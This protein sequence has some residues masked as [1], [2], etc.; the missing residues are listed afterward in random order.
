VLARYDY[1]Q[2]GRRARLTRG[3]GTKTEI[4]YDWGLNLWKLTHDLAWTDK[5]QNAE[6]R[7]NAANQIVGRVTSNPQYDW[8]INAHA[9]RRYRHDAQNKVVGNTPTGGIEQAITYHSSGTLASDGTSSFGYDADNRLTSVARPEKPSVALAYDA[10]GRLAR[11][12]STSGTER[13]LGYDGVEA[14]AEYD[15]NGTLLRRYVHGPGT[16]ELVAWYDWAGPEDVRYSVADE[17]GSIVAVTDRSGG[18]TVNTYDEYGVQRTETPVNRG[19]FQYTGQMWLP[20][21]GLYHYKARAYSPTLG[22]FLQPDPIGYD[23]GMN[24]YGYVGGDPVN[25][26]DPTGLACDQTPRPGGT[27]EVQEVVVCGKRQLQPSPSLVLGRKDPASM[28]PE[29]LFA[30]FG[31]P[32]YGRNEPYE[33]TDAEIEAMVRRARTHISATP[34]PVQSV[35]PFVPYCHDLYAGDNR[36]MSTRGG[37]DLSGKGA[38]PLAQQK[39]GRSLLNTHPVRVEF[40]GIFGTKHSTNVTVSSFAGSYPLSTP[41]GTYNVLRPGKLM[42]EFSSAGSVRVCGR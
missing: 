26:T 5:D 6:F 42:A 15:A 35:G 1:D 36:N 20:E 16:D 17:R 38:S 9:D 31:I 2:W 40:R 41:A 13:G 39:N 7:Y 29:E 24:L 30:L 32:M 10:A 33:P 37:F 3:D 28:T 25:G 18:T 12:T 27:G 8:R 11:V 19:V 34:K 21:A 22:R 4:I 14:I 23:D